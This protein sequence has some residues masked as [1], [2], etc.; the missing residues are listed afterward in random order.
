MTEH[1]ELFS[2][3]AAYE[4]MM[5]RWSRVAG[6]L[7]LDWIELPSGLRCLDVGCGNGAFTEELIARCAPA[8]VVG[9]DPSKQQI[10]TATP[11]SEGG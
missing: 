3:G 9:L 7:F 1:D 4:R 10:A 11:R 2:D 8:S 5:G 6:K